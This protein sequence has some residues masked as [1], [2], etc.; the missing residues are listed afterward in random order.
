M[1]YH[2]ECL[3]ELPKPCKSELEG[4]GLTQED[5][6]YLVSLIRFKKVFHKNNRLCPKCTDRLKTPVHA[7]ANKSGVRVCINC[8]TIVKRR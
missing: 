4:M 2:W 8:N 5:F 3:V 1:L 6:D 7:Y